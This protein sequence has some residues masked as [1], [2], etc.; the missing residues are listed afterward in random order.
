[1]NTAFGLS[2]AQ[3]ERAVLPLVVSDDSGFIASAAIDESDMVLTG[4]A[5][6][7]WSRITEPGDALAG[8]LVSKLG[9]VESIQGVIDGL[10]ADVLCNRAFGLRGHPSNSVTD[11]SALRVI[12]SSSNEHEFIARLDKALS[13]WRLRLDSQRCFGDFE[14]AGRMGAKLLVPEHKA[15]PNQLNDLGAHAPHALWCS[16]NTDILRS[17]SIAVVGSRAATSYGEQVTTNI[18]HGLVKN[19]VTI[20]SGG[21]FGIDAVAHRAALYRDGSTIAVLA[22]G[23]DRR[24]PSANEALF[25]RIASHGLLCAEQAPGSSPTKWRFLQRNRIIAALAHATLVCE[26]GH[27]SGSLNTAGHASELSRTLGAVPGPVTSAASAGC[28]RLLREYSAIC[29]RNSADALELMPE[30]VLPS[31]RSDNSENFPS[32]SPTHRRVLDALSSRK[33][34]SPEEISRSSGMDVFE[35]ADALAELNLMG[36]ISCSPRGWLLSRPHHSR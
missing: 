2:F 8:W 22:G 30:H 26:A 16:G 34:K 15:W 24:Y 6:G 1:M 5:R 20:V 13:A 32:Q 29:V 12:N 17:H 14:T 23:L 19:E 36:L 33:P 21:A 4:F 7:I 27:R 35:A 31:A 25:E 11:S 28:H 18:V 3:I 9:A 10:S